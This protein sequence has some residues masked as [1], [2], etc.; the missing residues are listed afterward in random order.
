MAEI[1]VMLIYSDFVSQRMGANGAIHFPQY[2]F[3]YTLW[4]FVRR[5]LLTPDCDANFYGVFVPVIVFLTECS[6]MTSTGLLTI[7]VIFLCERKAQGC[8]NVSVRLGRNDRRICLNPDV[9][10]MI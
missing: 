9:F 5:D 3:F 7:D 6:E 2:E 8:E 4:M 1:L 10:K